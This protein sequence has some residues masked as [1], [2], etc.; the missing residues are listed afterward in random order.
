MKKEQLEYV[1]NQINKIRNSVENKQHRLAWPI[2]M[3]LVE[4]KASQDQNQK[5]TNQEER[6]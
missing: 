5:A 4:V 1:Q 2:L 6:L 3:K